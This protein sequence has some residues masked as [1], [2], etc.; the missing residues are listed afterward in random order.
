MNI[1][2]LRLAQIEVDLTFIW[3][4]SQ[5]PQLGFDFLDEL[6]KAIRRIVV[7][8]DSCAEISSGLRRCLLNRFPFGLIYGKDQD[9][10]VIVAVAHLHR[11]PQYWLD[12]VR[13]GS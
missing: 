4:E 10:L 1:R 13:S 11:E 7:Y 6:D 2:F 8:P 3:Y 12:R 9:V 5:V